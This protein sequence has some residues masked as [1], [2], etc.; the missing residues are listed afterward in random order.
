MR[1][2]LSSSVSLV[3]ITV[4]S[5]LLTGVAVLGLTLGVLTSGTSA[6][7]EPIGGTEE[8]ADDISVSSAGGGTTFG[9]TRRS[10]G[11]GPVKRGCLLRRLEVD[12]GEEKQSGGFGVVF[13]GAI[14]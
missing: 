2:R 6:S 13:L 5:E 1:N 10:G 4:G 7:G 14:R 12:E 3:C 8:E 9:L 11:K